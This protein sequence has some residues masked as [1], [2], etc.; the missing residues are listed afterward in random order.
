M[1][2]VELVASLQQYY[3]NLQSKKT[4]GD[5][6]EDDKLLKTSKAENCQ[7]DLDLPKQP[8]VVDVISPISESRCGQNL[9]PPGKVKRG[10]NSGS[11]LRTEETQKAN[12]TLQ[13]E[14]AKAT[15]SLVITPKRNQTP[16]SP[17]PCNK[18]K[19]LRLNN[20]KASQEVSVIQTKSEERTLKWALP[21][22]AI[23]PTSCHPV[24]ESTDLDS[25]RRKTYSVSP[26]LK[27]DDKLKADLV[28][29]LEQRIQKKCKLFSYQ[30]VCLCRY[31]V[32]GCVFF[33]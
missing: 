2:N 29:E 4:H 33:A 27:S 8:S 10:R 23:C 26:Q 25:T 3:E 18:L 14:R 20:K 17:T 22:D 30:L 24:K 5:D 28:S 6:L 12:V 19:D 9:V 31:R 32:L 1:Q 21:S 11:A 7:P 15:T 13:G 16:K